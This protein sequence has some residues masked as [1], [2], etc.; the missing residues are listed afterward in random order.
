[1]FF[2]DKGIWNKSL[3]SYKLIDGATVFPKT[4][5]NIS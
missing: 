3:E 4:T 1:M 5:L 2:V